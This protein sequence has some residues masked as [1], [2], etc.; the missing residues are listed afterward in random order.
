M[1]L[2]HEI[3]APIA[4]LAGPVFN[5]DGEVAGDLPLPLTKLMRLA[6]IEVD[7]CR[8]LIL[9]GVQEYTLVLIPFS[10]FYHINSR[11]PLISQ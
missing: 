6:A 7:Q 8:S 3:S 1:L 11:N 4:S 5:M 10:S 2:L 9:Y